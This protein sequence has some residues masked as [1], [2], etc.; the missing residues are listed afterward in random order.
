MNKT[1]VT[2]LMDKAKKLQVEHLS[3]TAE[4]E[5]IEANISK[6]HQRLL[7]IRELQHPIATQYE[8]LLGVLRAEGIEI[9]PL[10]PNA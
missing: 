9:G 2:E 3:L 6:G 4:A 8:N 5:R 7:N 10:G 1:T